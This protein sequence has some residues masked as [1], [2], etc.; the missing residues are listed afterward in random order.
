MKHT[1]A[2]CLRSIFAD[3]QPQVVS[4]NQRFIMNSKFSQKSS[5]LI[6]SFLIL[7]V[8]LFAQEF[9]GNI[10]GRV[11]DPHGAFVPNA[12][13]S[14]QIE[15]D[16]KTADV[17]HSRTVLTDEEG[18]FLIEHLTVRAF[19]VKAYFDGMSYENK[20]VEVKADETLNLNIK[21]SYGDCDKNANGKTLR[22]G[23]K[24]KAEIIN[25]ILKEQLTAKKLTD[26]ELYFKKDKPLVI[27]TSNIKTDWVRSFADIKMDLLSRE[28]IQAKADQYGD[29]RY[30]SFRDWDIAENCVIVTFIN[31]WA[32]G[33]KSDNIYL[34]GRGTI[35][36]FRR[37]SGKWAGRSIGGWV[38]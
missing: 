26:N 11:V 22:I 28:E 20:S 19:E 3:I 27:S 17:Q 8:N 1:Q 2:G 38:S 29:F 23:D 5:L 12:T 25:Q 6:F 14:I 18:K 24:D 35:Y 34:D 4:V 30:V 36:S 37:E 33:E 16:P 13:V 21:L 31:S 10:S 32:V 9:T 7:S 15:S